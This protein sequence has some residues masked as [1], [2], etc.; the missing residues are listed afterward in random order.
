MIDK[1]ALEICVTQIRYVLERKTLKF[2]MQF[3]SD[4]LRKIF[5]N[6]RTSN[7]FLGKSNTIQK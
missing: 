1:S 5:L 7:E 2:F 4:M 3:I 6:V